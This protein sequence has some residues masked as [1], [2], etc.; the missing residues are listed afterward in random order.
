MAPTSRAYFAY[1]ALLDPQTFARRVGEEGNASFRL[2]EGKVAEAQDVDLVFN[3]HSPRWGGRIASLVAM[4]GHTVFGRLLQ[5]DEADFQLVRRA[6]GGKSGAF[7]EMAVRVKVDGKVVEA[8]ALGRDDGA[9][10]IDANAEKL[11][12]VPKLLRR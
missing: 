2:P 6:E 12:R 8:V 5:L 9:F 3:Y 10:R 4:P 11:R 1:S 7:R